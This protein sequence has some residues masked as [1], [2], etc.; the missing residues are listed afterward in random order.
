MRTILAIFA[1]VGWTTTAGAQEWVLGA[2]YADFSNR[3]SQD[4][5]MI[6]LEYHRDP[7]YSRGRLQVGVSAAVDADTSGDLFVGIGLGGV[8]DLN[9]RWFL[10]GSVLPGAFFEAVAQNDLGSTFEI[11]SLLGVGYVLASGTRISL[12]LSHKSNAGTASVNPGLNSVL[13]RWRR[14]F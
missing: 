3:A 5:A 6:A 10:E 11:R 12:A 7:F 14:R 9:G 1:L 4:Q 2:G 8:Y 13:I